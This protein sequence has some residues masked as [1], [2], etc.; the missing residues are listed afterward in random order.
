MTSDSNSIYQPPTSNVE[1]EHHG[2]ADQGSLARGVAGE[3]DL[4]IGDVFSEAWQLV[5][6]SKGVIIGSL[7]VLYMV[8]FGVL[9]LVF[10]LWPPV[11]GEQPVQAQ[12]VNFASNFITYP[13]MGGMMIY[14]VKRAAKDP[15]ASFADTFA[16]FSRVLPIVL[17]YIFQGLLM[18]FGFLLL[19]LP[20][21]YL[22]VAY[23]LALPLLLDKQLG[24]WAAL[25]T[26][27][28]AITNV[29]FKFAAIVF[30][31]SLAATFGT[32]L[33]LG[34]FSMTTVEAEGQVERVTD[35]GAQ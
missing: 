14:A 26:S 19:V 2:A 30:V 35:G 27:R 7:V 28:K 23:V 22:A 21:I 31:A 25:E 17:L 34:I 10:V 12:I 20:G 16:Y 32:I 8:A 24:V 18:V 3:F 29:W 5:S 11:N 13:I 6:G 15:S 1:R 9:A 4:Q 33:T